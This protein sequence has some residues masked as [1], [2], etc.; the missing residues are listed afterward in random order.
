VKRNLFNVC[1]I[2]MFL[3]CFSQR[4]VDNSNVTLLIL[5]FAFIEKSD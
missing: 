3:H 1:I 4:H 2:K 5:W